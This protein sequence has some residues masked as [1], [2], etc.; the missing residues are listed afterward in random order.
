MNFLSLA[1]NAHLIGVFLAIRL[2]LPI[3][4]SWLLEQPLNEG[5]LQDYDAEKLAKFVGE[6]PL[7]AGHVMAVVMLEKAMR[8]DAKAFEFI[9]DTIGEK[10]KDNKET[11]GAEFPKIQVKR[12]ERR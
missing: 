2:N 3:P 1:V 4:S 10:P 6:E 11:V 5:I 8:G 7:T 9:R 12:M